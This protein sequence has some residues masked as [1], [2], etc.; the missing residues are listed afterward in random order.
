M[1]FNQDKSVK[2]FGLFI[3]KRMYY[4]RFFFVATKQYCFTII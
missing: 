4:F 3:E 2:S 1:K